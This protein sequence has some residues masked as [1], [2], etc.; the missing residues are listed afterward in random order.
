MKLLSSFAIMRDVANVIQISFAYNVYGET[1]N[2]ERVNVQEYFAVLAE[3]DISVIG[4]LEEKIKTHLDSVDV[5]IHFISGVSVAND[6][7]GKKRITYYYNSYN[8]E[9]SALIRENV[10]NTYLV[11][12]AETNN[13]IENV[14]EIIKLKL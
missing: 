8:K 11:L 9:T 13:L 2:I 5:N 1:G 14:E 7:I 6:I 3:N 12:D 10:K 4:S